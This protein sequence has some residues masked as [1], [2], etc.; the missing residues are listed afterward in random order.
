MCVCMHLDLSIELS[1]MCLAL[2]DLVCG[3][4]CVVYMQGFPKLTKSCSH[5]LKILLTSADLKADCK[6]NNGK[7]GY[8]S[9]WLIW[10]VCREPLTSGVF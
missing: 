4:V 3:S 5:F 1:F 6:R 8:S 7:N 2:Y 10:L 9:K